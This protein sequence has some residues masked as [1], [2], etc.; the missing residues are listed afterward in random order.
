MNNNKMLKKILFLTGTRADFGK[1]KPLINVCNDSDLLD[2]YIFATGMHMH[3]KY[4]FTVKEIEKLGFKNIFKFINYTSEKSMDLTLSKTIEGLSSYVKEERPNMIIVHGD[5]LEALAGAIVGAMNNILVGHVEGG[6]VSGTIDDLLR[7]ATSKMAHLHFVASETAEKR[8]IQL[9]E[10]SDSIFK[11]GSPDVD[12]MLS[13]KLPTLD[14]V[15]KH[16]EIPFDKYA[17]AMLHPVTTELELIE[18]QAKVFAKSLIDSG[19]NYVVVYPN[20]D[21]GSEYILKVYEKYLKN[22]SN[23]ILFP[24]LRFE[25]FL[26]LLKNANFLIGNSS[27][28]I[29]EAPVYGI[30]TINIGSRQE[31]R[32]EYQSINN[33]DFDL[34]KI[35]EV[36]KKVKK[37]GKYNPTNHYG[38]GDS[39]DK[40]IKLIEGMEIWKTN[41]QKKFIDL[42]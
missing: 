31:N 4:G 23:F 39:A 8:L 11:I 37:I 29:H 40:F 22:N 5:R 20:N 18:N 38:T 10:S 1:L 2:V 12:I 41:A 7:H 3:K 33:V 30:P 21:M 26:T 17:I 15:I 9:G 14:N 16:Y 6:E 13:D 36:I 24:S 34:D 35:L 25:Y 28:G 27:T 32:F 42:V 19:E